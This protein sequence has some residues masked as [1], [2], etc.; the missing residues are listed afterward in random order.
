MSEISEIISKNDLFS[1][2]KIDSIIFKGGKFAEKCKGVIISLSNLKN[3]FP[4]SSENIPILSIFQAFMVKEIGSGYGLDINILN[5]GTKLLINNMEN[6]LSSIRDL[7]KD[8]K[9]KEDDLLDILDTKEILN[10]LEIIKNK[11][12][13][14]LE[15]NNK[16]SILSLANCEKRK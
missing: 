2:I 5:S 10:S 13:N 15:K 14:K 3:I 16:N 1:K 4:S 12:K 8:N 9:N 6:L 11:V 7:K